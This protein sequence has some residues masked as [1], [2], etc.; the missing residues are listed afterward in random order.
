MAQEMYP[1]MQ[2]T[3]TMDPAKLPTL[4]LSPRFLTYNLFGL[5]TAPYTKGLQ[6]V[7]GNSGKGMGHHIQP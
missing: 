1:A 5:L 2:E 4:G 6:E 3:S 7:L